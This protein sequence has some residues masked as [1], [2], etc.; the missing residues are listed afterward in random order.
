MR[1]SQ[2]T[3]NANMDLSNT[4]PGRDSVVVVLDKDRLPSRSYVQRLHG[5]NMPSVEVADIS[6]AIDRLSDFTTDSWPDVLVVKGASTNMLG[7]MA[8]VCR[9]AGV[10]LV[11]EHDSGRGKPAQFP[12]R[13]PEPALAA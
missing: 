9:A 11:T 12:A 2:V 1:Q 5:G 10:R 6:E 4:S 3:D 13:R 8:D 7:L